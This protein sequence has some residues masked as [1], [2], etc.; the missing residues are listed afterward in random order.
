MKNKK[1][2]AALILAALTLLLLLC[3]CG[4][5]KAADIPDPTDAFYVYDE[6]NVLDSETEEYIIGK[7]ADL[8]KK[9][10]GQI[11]VAC[12][13]T[14]GAADIKDYA[15]DMF[16]KW[17]VGSNSRN[18]GILILLSIDEDDYWVLQGKG[19]EDL[20]QSGTLKLMLDTD[21][22]PFFAKRQYADGV[23][24]LFDSLIEQFEQIYSISVVQLSASSVGS[25]TPEPSDAAAAESGKFSLWNL[26]K[27]F[28]GVIVA[29]SVAVIVIII[30][31][32]IV[33]TV[34]IIISSVLSAGGG[35][36][37]PRSTFRGGINV[38]PHTFRPH[39]TY[40]GGNFNFGGSR[41]SGGFNFGG[42]RHSGGFNFGGS[43]HSGGSFGGSHGGFSGGSRHSGGG[44]SSRGGGAGR[45]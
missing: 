13:D 18:N 26:I 30:I 1:R 27:T 11:V 37:P 25:Y 32:S 9:C 40:H 29:V 36:R 34:F 21:L 19:L 38:N 20:I 39:N 3:S 23:R 44:G 8:Y 15:L 31:I 35:V 24:S 5:K 22:E 6:A 41:H 10:G 12:V 16:N 2:A 42:T 43:H 17:G 28:S 4:R 7:N 33:V 14:T 45:R